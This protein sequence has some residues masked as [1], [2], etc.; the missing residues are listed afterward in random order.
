MSV[1]SAKQHIEQAKAYLAENRLD[2]AEAQLRQAIA[3]D[4]REVSARVELARLLGAMGRFDECCQF[5]DEALQIAPEDPDALTLKG[6]NLIVQDRHKEAI[7][8]LRRAL[9]LNPKQL[10]A[11]VHL[12][13]ALRET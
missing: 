10:I 11:Q 8:V 6:M 13:M 1:A 7:E 9:A 4:R 12:G 2:E 5:A 3:I